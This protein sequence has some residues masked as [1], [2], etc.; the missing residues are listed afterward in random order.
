[1]ASGMLDEGGRC[2]LTGLLPSE[3]GCSHHRNSEVALRLD[4][5]KST[6]YMTA[7][8]SGRCALS[9]D[10]SIT[11]GERIGHT[12]HGWACNRCVRDAKGVGH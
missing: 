11:P 7:L 5:V 6:G 8:Y 12:E 9:E 3:C 4:G 10:H 2:V 1:M